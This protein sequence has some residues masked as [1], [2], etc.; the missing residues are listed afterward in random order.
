MMKPDDDFPLRICGACHSVC[1]AESD[2]CQHCGHVFDPAEDEAPAE[3]TP[4]PAPKSRSNAGEWL[5]VCLAEYRVWTK[6]GAPRNAPRTVR[7][8]YALTNGGTIS[9][10]LCPEH[11]GYA[12]SKFEKWWRE[13][14]S[15][16]SAMPP[17][18]AEEC[19]RLMSEGAVKDVTAVFV[20]SSPGDPYPRV[21]AYDFT[22][23]DGPFPF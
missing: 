1:W 9:E 10:W 19:A 12:R 22:R 4:E 5:E 6:R 3:P 23:R 16:D 14:R 13:H 15:Q 17:D 2:S 8:D 18:N 11:S 21:E 20:R 7:A